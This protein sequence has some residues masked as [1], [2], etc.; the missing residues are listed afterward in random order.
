MTNT[1]I[2]PLAFSTGPIFFSTVKF[3]SSFTLKLKY[4]KKRN[5]HVL[6][7][8]NSESGEKNPLFK[9]I[10]TF[11]NMIFVSKVLHVVLIIMNIYN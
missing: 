7:A 3:G 2:P 11:S 6:Y 9:I 1:R 4:K 10:I 5:F 8:D